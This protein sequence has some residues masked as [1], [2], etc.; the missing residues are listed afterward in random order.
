MG[1]SPF[2]S[3]LQSRDRQGAVSP[4]TRDR[5]KLPEHPRIDSQQSRDHR[6]R[7]APKKRDRLKLPEHPR[8]DSLPSRDRQG[9][10]S[11][12]NEKR[13]RHPSPAP[14]QGDAP[15]L[16]YRCARRRRSGRRL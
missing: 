16:L 4:F 6:E 9:A 2:F 3:N 8:I 7:S 1:L 15:L 12:Q 10:A 14:S 5:P 13:G 11:P